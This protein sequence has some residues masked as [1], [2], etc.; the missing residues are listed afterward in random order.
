MCSTCKIAAFFLRRVCETV[1]WVFPPRHDRTEPCQVLRE[2]A[3]KIA[4]STGEGIQTCSLP[5]TTT[6]K[7]SVLSAVIYRAQPSSPFL[8]LF[9]FRPFFPPAPLV[10]RAPPRLISIN[11]IPLKTP[12]SKH[13]FQPSTPIYPVNFSPNELTNNLSPWKMR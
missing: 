12:R 9:F 11:R 10:L 2:P 7:V 6:T 5:S 8:S 4:S 1:G 3:L 13:Q